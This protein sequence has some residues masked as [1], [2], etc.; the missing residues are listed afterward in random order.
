M[1][2]Q[3]F[4]CSIASCSREEANEKAIDYRQCDRRGAGVRY[5]RLRGP[6]QSGRSRDRRRSGW[7]GHRRGGRRWCGRR[8]RCCYHASAPTLQSPPSPPCGVSLLLSRTAR[9]RI[10]R[11]QQSRAAA[12]C[13]G[14]APCP[15]MRSHRS[16]L[17]LRGSRRRDQ[18]S[19]QPGSLAEPLFLGWSWRG[20]E[21]SRQEV[22][23]H[24]P[25][26]STKEAWQW[27]PVKHRLRTRQRSIRG[28]P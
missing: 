26:A 16:A 8:R 7:C 3:S 15:R 12:G 23:R 11:R 27:R 13:L 21:G 28:A 22:S 2:R 20:D 19:D 10:G 1:I 6:V 9:R 25:V 14:A 5:H 24:L 18:P 4:A 17:P